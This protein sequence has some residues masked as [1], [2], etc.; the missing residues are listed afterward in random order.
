MARYKYLLWDIDGTVLDF[1]AAEKAALKMLF[2]K[3]GFGECT[4]ERIARYSAINVKY[5]QALERNEM[6]KPEILVGRFREFF[7][8]EG[9]DSS[10][11]ADF[12]NDY[13]VALGDTIVFCDN[14]DVLLKELKGKFV[15]AAITNG[16]SVAQIKKLALSGLSDIFDYTFISEEVGV[17]KPNM[18][19]FDKVIEEMKLEDLSQALVIG[20]SLTSDIKGGNNAGIDTCWYNPYNKEKNTDAHVDYEIHNLNEIMAIIEG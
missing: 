10:R 19:F 12:N 11:A 7:E 17:E 16:T 8:T 9:L 1:L 4:D 13:Q 15:L 20:D 3:Y 6:T 14:S 5:W 18:G 2:I